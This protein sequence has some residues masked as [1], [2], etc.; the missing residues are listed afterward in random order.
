MTSMIQETIN[1]FFC[2]PESIVFF[3]Y[4]SE[5][6]S[7]YIKKWGLLFRINI[8]FILKFKVFAFSLII[9]FMVQNLHQ[10]QTK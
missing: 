3:Y 10:Q 2:S 6:I 4:L 5:L 9:V 1:P 8:Y 7:A